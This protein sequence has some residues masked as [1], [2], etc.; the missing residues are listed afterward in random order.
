MAEPSAGKLI[1]LS[2][3]SGVGKSTLIKRLL[4]RFPGRLRLSVSATTRDPR[5]GEIEGADYYFLTP[6][7]FQRR[8]TAGEFLECCQVFSQG[9]WYGTLLSE[10]SPSL[11]AG[12]WVLLE[13]DVEGTR[14]VLE[15]YPDAVT[16]FV[17]PG[18]E[19][20]LERRLRDRATESEEAIRR[21]L[22]VARAEL[23]R[24]DGYAYRVVNDHV[25]EAV[26]QIAQILTSCRSHSE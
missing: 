1:V 6:E 3:P 22:E 21:R 16:L 12:K 20:E 4:D 7:E 18:S 19:E 2:G 25:E 11:D 23:A 26:E 8:R 9:H 24:A 10:V 17:E 5:P 15:H 13:I 14:A